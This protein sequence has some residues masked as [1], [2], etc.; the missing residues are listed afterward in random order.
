M[1]S[2]QLPLQEEE[3][4]ILRQIQQKTAKANMDNISRTEAYANFY[5]RYPE[6]KWS[7]LAS[8]VS[9]NAGW[10]MCD[11]EGRWM[12]LTLDPYIRT[13]L[14]LTYER[15]NWL[16]FAD[17]YPQLLLYELSV[18]RG[19]PYFHL[20][21]YW[22]TSSFIQK[23]WILFWHERN[24]QRLITSLIINEQNVIQKPVMDHP[25]YKKK[26]FRSF[27]FKF[28]DWLHFSSVIFPTRQGELFGC[29]V[30]DFRN[31][32][33]RIELGKK[34]SLLL[35]EPSLYPRFL[36]FSN[37]VTH[38]GSRIDYERYMEKR[39]IRDT[40]FLRMTYPVIRHHQ[41]NGNEWSASNRQIK[42]W[43]K[44]ALFPEKANVTEWYKKK[45]MQ[46]QLLIQLEQYIRHFG[47]G[48]FF[49]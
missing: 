4:D 49:R 34:L 43:F 3:R 26:V 12:P 27:M 7:F 2:A 23:E 20:L 10:N 5:R 18:L 17:A 24:E 30:H 19:K 39:K 45:Q 9:R 37:Q 46:L 21:P 15:A 40:P 22:R 48:D 28:Q 35:F 13:L 29:S 8:M 25:F 33:K 47:K 41:S 42:R 11:L 31:K 36:E 6:I 44:P 14:F 1:N 32:T 16:I 38:T